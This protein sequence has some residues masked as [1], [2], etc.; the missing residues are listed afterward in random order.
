LSYF[1]TDMVFF[2]RKNKQIELRRNEANSK[3]RKA[4]YTVLCDLSHSLLY[5]YVR[6]DRIVKNQTQTFLTTFI[7]SSSILELQLRSDAS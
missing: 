6:S 2:H 3:P 4:I 5:N 1:V 7:A